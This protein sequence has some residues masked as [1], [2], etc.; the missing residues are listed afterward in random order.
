MTN[1]AICLTL[2]IFL[3]T[4]MPLSLL[5]QSCADTGD[6]K[7]GQDIRQQRTKFNAAI[8]HGD[9]ETIESV[10][11]QDVILITGTDSD[12]YRGRDSQLAIWQEDFDQAERAVYVR[13]TM[14]VRVS[15]SFPIALEY[16]AWRGVQNN[17]AEDFAAGLYSAK[18]R[19]VDGSWL[20]ESEVFA[21][22]RC[23][24]TFCPDRQEAE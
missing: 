11:H 13:T 9:I 22:E 1:P 12:V 15:P 8:E 19:L 21:T 4:L 7:A 20:I 17:R 24:G 6:K 2:I 14:C 18:W 3:T 23:G 16:G 10:L 5:A